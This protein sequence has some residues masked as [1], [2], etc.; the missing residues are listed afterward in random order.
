MAAVRNITIYQGD[1]Y[2]HEL[3]LRNSA[4]VAINITTRT[5]AGAIRK[6]RSSEE[7]TVVFTTEITDGA[8]G[9]VVMSL[10]PAQTANIPPGTY[11]YDFQETNGPVVTTL[12]TGNV[13]ITGEVYKNG[14]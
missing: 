6:R 12:L 5:Y 7:V 11:V 1:T 13:S 14:I 10:S 8:N 4:N 2:T 9:V 3:K